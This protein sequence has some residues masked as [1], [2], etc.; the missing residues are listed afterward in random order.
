METLVSKAHAELDDSVERIVNAAETFIH[1]QSDKGIAAL[2]IDDVPL[3]L[4]F[5]PHTAELLRSIHAGPPGSQEDALVAF[6]DSEQGV[7]IEIS[8]PFSKNLGLPLSSAAFSAVTTSMAQESF[9]KSGAI[10][11]HV[12]L[13]QSALQAVRHRTELF[14]RAVASRASLEVGEDGMMKET[15]DSRATLRDIRSYLHPGRAEKKAAAQTQVSGNAI[16][17]MKVSSEPSSES[18]MQ[19]QSYKR[20]R[21]VMEGIEVDAKLITALGEASSSG[22][23][24]AQRSIV[25]AFANGKKSLT[26]YESAVASLKGNNVSPDAW[27][28]KSS[29]VL[30]FLSGK[31]TKNGKVFE[32]HLILDY[33]DTGKWTMKAQKP[34][35]QSASAPTS[36]Q[37]PTTTSIDHSGQDKESGSS[38]VVSEGA[39]LKQE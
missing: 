29:G 31:V 19:Q 2:S 26:D 27:Q 1:A 39:Q 6:H 10:G 34:Q 16:G 23:T 37:P 28:S 14:E 18:Q 25:E 24:F 15:D 30:D 36:T 13:T 22:L 33:N 21:A 5:Q 38:K 32:V 12:C 7:P 9:A 20:K 17:M 3:S 11:S 8:A 4:R 35:S